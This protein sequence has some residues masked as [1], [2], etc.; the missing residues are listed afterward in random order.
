MKPCFPGTTCGHKGQRPRTLRAM[1]RHYI[2]YKR[3]CAQHELE[4]FAKLPY[5]EALERAA[6]AKDGR[7]KR[8]SHQTRLEGSK[9]RKARNILLDAAEELRQCKSFDQLHYLIKEHL[10][11]I[12]G[13]GEL[14]YYDT[15]LRIGA[16]LRL[17]LSD[18]PN[19]AMYDHLASGHIREG[20]RGSER[21]TE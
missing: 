18:H 15:A 9:L 4:S 6:L 2:F 16:S 14:Y 5:E 7:G 20:F 19:P 10:N 11:S 17:I 12:Q 1:V 21:A 13:L 8:F 3:P